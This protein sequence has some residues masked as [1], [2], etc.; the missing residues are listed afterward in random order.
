MKFLPIIM[1]VVFFLCGGSIGLLV[2]QK[3][4]PSLSEKA[5]CV[6]ASHDELDTFYTSI[7]GVTE[8]QKKTL[9]PIEEEYLK[10]KR[11]YTEEMAAAN[12][13]LAKI[14]EE[15]G[16]KD[17]NVADVIMDIHG[18]MGS[19]QHLTLQHLAQIQTVLTAEQA[20]LLKDHVVERL[21]Q[22]Q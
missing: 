20:E 9:G 2:G 11:Q 6:L 7:L 13:R 12:H 18:A 8:E 4:A 21:R 22:N 3:T 17:E 5:H 19:L 10:E 16:Y 15:K 1:L 14:I